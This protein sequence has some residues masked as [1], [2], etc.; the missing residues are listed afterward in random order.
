MAGARVDQVHVARSTLVLLEGRNFFRIRRPNE[1][2]PIAVRPAG[3][4]CRVAKGFHAISRKLGVFSG[5]NV[6][7]PEVVIAN[8]SRALLI[9]R[10]DFP[11][12]AATSTEGRTLTAG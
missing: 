7:H 2:R 9:G 10:S 4:V 11:W 12:R 8:E 6:A 5:R 1:H 3:V